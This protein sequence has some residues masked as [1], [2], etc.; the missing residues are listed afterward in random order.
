MGTPE[1]WDGGEEAPGRVPAP[2][3]GPGSY[4][5]HEDGS[6]SFVGDD[7]WP[8]GAEE[9]YAE[10]TG[11]VATPPVIDVQPESVT[12]FEVDSSDRRPRN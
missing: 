2:T 11:A 10:L 5:H 1:L 6:W 8:V 9:F 12:D 3:A 7:G 4:L